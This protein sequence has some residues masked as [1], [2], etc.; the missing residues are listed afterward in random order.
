MAALDDILGC[1]VF[2]CTVA[3][4]AGNLSAGNLSAY[5]IPLVVILPLAIGVVTRIIGRCC[6]EK[7]K[8]YT[9]NFDISYDFNFIGFKLGI[10]GKLFIA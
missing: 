6:A 5:I 4:V 10:L 8:Q 1:I 9:I 7:R 2:F 3:I